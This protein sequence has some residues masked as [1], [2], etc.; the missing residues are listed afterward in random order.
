MVEMNVDGPTVVSTPIT[1][2]VSLVLLLTRIS[3]FIAMFIWVIDKFAR[4]EHVAA[5]FES[6]YGI[7]GVG[8]LASY[9]LGAVQLLIMLG[10]LIGFQKRITYGLVLL[11]HTASTLISFPKYLAPFESAN[12]L[13]YAAWPMLAACFALYYLRDLDTRAAVE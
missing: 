6:F 1:R 13:F 4:P 12:I 8:A 9:A 7:S 5:V 10:F 11:M 3:I 2:R